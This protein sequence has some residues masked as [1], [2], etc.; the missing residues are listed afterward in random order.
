MEPA[1]HKAA[2]LKD[3]RD[4]TA[5]PGPNAERHGP[6]SLNICA[7]TLDSV[8]RIFYVACAIPPFEIPLW[9]R[10]GGERRKLFV[11]E[12]LSAKTPPESANRA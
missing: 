3:R 5:R 12:I 1:T 7:R 9:L 6:R 11:I 8:A 10:F 2:P 4:D